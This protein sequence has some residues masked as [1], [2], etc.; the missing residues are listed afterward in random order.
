MYIEIV[1]NESKL[2]I[3]FLNDKIYQEIKKNVESC[4]GWGPN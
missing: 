3:P 2:N 1:S 4:Q